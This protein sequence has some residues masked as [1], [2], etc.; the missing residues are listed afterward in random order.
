VVALAG[1]LVL[2]AAGAAV[3]LTDAFGTHKSRSLTGGPAYLGLQIGPPALTGGLLITGVDSGSPAARAGVRPGDV[4]SRLGG[5]QVHTPGDVKALMQGRHP[6]DQLELSVDR[7]A[8]S[9]T[10][11]VTLTGGP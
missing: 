5:V 7:G 8:Y 3:A 1:I 2:L 9:F 10:A 6:G 11:D 4:L